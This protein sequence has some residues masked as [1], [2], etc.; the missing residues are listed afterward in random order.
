MESGY[1]VLMDNENPMCQ[2]HLNGCDLKMVPVQF[3]SVQFTVE[4]VDV[5]MESSEYILE[6]F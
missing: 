6:N 1:I 5:L 2:L 3:S 4:G